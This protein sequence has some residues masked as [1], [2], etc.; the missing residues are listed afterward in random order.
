MALPAFLGVTGLAHPN[1]TVPVTTVPIVAPTCGLGDVLVAVLTNPQGSAGFT[2]PGGWDTV[3]NPP[4]DT[5]GTVPQVAIFFKR[6]LATDSGATFTFTTAEGGG[7]AFGFMLAVSN[8]V[9]GVEQNALNSADSG[10]GSPGA[11]TITT[12]SVVT[13]RPNQLVYEVIFA[14]PYSDSDL[15]FGPKPATVRLFDALFGVLLCEQPQSTSG[16]TPPQSVTLATP[17]GR[18]SAATFSLYSNDAPNAPTL[19]SPPD[20]SFVNIAAGQRFNFNFSDIDPGDFQSAFDFEYTAD[21]G[22]TWTT[23]S[24]DALSGFGSLPFLDF[25]AGTFSDGV[26]YQW[27]V[28]TYDSYGAQGPWS[29][30]FSFTGAAVPG[31]PTILTPISDEVIGDS[32]VDL[33]WSGGSQDGWEARLVGDIAGSPDLSSVFWDSGEILDGTLEVLV[34]LDETGVTR[35][36][37]VRRLFDSLWSDWADVRFSAD[38]D[39]PPAPSLTLST[40]DDPPTITVYFTIP[41]TVVGELDTCYNDLLMSIGAGRTWVRVATK[42]SLNAQWVYWLPACG[43][44]YLFRPVAYSHAGSYEYGDPVVVAFVDEGSPA[45]L[46]PLIPGGSP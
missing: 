34:A 27:R 2:A 20:G 22:A 4:E 24:K 30:T 18:W 15:T 7:S 42:L 32:T 44:T 26:A 6:A 16:S 19:V 3:Q 46:P 21:S 23:V 1:S 14:R 9:F 33:T 31:A 41:A 17:G 45:Y 29:S 11:L 43:L 12:P 25:A 28:R 5:L 13:S 35:H 38:F 10:A 40:N 37:Q 36:L 8:L 39:K